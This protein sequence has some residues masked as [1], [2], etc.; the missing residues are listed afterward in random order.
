[1]DRETDTWLDGCIQHMVKCLPV[2]SP[3]LAPEDRETDGT[4]AEHQRHSQSTRKKRHC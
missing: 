4:C 2:P 3:L 1:M